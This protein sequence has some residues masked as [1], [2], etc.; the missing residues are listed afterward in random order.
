MMNWERAERGGSGEREGMAFFFFFPSF[1]L[2]LV[3][4]IWFLL[5]TSFSG[6]FQMIIWKSGVAALI[7]R[8]YTLPRD[9]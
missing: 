4:I 1:L 2:S 5:A 8:H 3:C 7:Q 6:F 9:Y